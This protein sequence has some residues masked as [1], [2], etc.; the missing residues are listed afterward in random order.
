MLIYKITEVKYCTSLRQYHEVP[1]A[2]NINEA[3]AYAPCVQHHRK[4]ILSAILLQKVEKS[5]F[6]Q[7]LPTGP[8]LCDAA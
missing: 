7:T 3:A 2:A 4:L 5:T 6:L 1:L 8:F